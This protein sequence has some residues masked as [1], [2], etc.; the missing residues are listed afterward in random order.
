MSTHSEEDPAVV[1]L[2]HWLREGGARFSKV[3]VASLGRGERGL[4]ALG[5]IAPEETL[6][7]IPARHVLTLEEA[8][9]SS[10]GGLLDAHAP[11]D[12]EWVYLAAFLLQE[13]ERG[14]RSFWKPFLDSLPKSFPSI[15]FFFEERELSLLKGS[16]APQL[17]RAQREGLKAQHGHLCKHVPGFEWFTFDAFVWAHFAVVTRT[18]SS[19]RGGNDA[20]CLVP[21]ADMINDGRPWDIHWGWSEDGT[22]FELKSTSAVA[23]GQELR[24]TYG[25]KSNLHLLLQYGFVHE[26]NAHDDVMLSLGLALEDPLA[27]EKQRLLGLASP[28]ELRPYMLSLTEDAQPLEEMFSFLRVVCA[29]AGELAS[30]AAAPDARARAQSPLSARNEQMLINAFTALCEEQLASY[31]TPLAEDER[32]LREE[33]LSQNARNCLLMLRGEKRI[34]QAYAGR[35]RSSGAL[36]APSREG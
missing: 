29:D 25:G 36:P 35:A 26:E 27:G 24:A 14:E 19:P 8:R 17:V 10:I 23:R 4:C 12:E 2:L 5:D 21:L 6:V 31:E 20:A 28:Y 13:K 22:H 3:H 7:R 32:R 9:S 1:P 16:L 18:F 30:L 33:K 11:A 15:P 34:L